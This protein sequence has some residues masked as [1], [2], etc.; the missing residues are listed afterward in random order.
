MI[1]LRSFTAAAVLTLASLTLESCKDGPIGP[2]AKGA[3]PAGAN[4]DGKVGDVGN[5]AK[6]GD[7][8]ARVLLDKA[9]NALLQV[10]T[11]TYNP[12]NNVA[13]PN[14]YFQSIQ[15]K[16]YD[17]KGKQVGVRNVKFKTDGI[18][19]YSA[20]IDLCGS[21]DLNDDDDEEAPAC[22]LRYQLSWSV[23]VQANL[24]GVGGDDKKTDVVREDGVD[25]YLPDID[26]TN[27]KLYTI[28]AGG[29]PS[30]ASAVP[31]AAPVTYTV[32]FP[33][34]K[35][36]NGVANTIGVVATCAVFVDG[37]PQVAVPNVP[38][39]GIY[40]NPYLF[41]Y[42]NGATQPIP[43]GTT[44]ACQFSLS[45][46]AGSHTIQV[47]AI[48]VLPGDYDYSNNGTSKFTVT[49]SSG[50]PDVAVY[51][52]LQK[53]VG[54][55]Y[56]P[57]GG[58]T[59]PSGATT[60][61]TTVYQQVV[62]SSLTTPSSVACTFKVDGTDLPSPSTVTPALNGVASSGYCSA[63]VTLAAGT[64]TVKVT[65]TS[66]PADG[67]P[68]NDTITTFVSVAPGPITGNLASQLFLV[69]STKTSIVPGPVSVL[70]GTTN[71]YSA[72]VSL[73]NLVNTA[74]PIPVSCTVLVDNMTM[75]AG[76][77]TLVTVGSST[78]T[79]LLTWGSGGSTLL[80]GNN[81]TG[82]CQ[83]SLT[84]TEN[85]N[86]DVV[87]SI[88]VI[89]TTNATASPTTTTT[90]G[91]VTNQVRVDLTA[92]G[93]YLVSNGALTQLVATGMGIKDTL[94]AVFHNP[95]AT[96]SV[97]F[98]CTVTLNGAAV[99]DTSYAGIK[100]SGTA[101]PGGDA[102]CRW[103]YRPL[104]LQSLPFVVTATP[105]AAAPVDPDLT[106]NAQGVTLAA[107]SNGKFTGFDPDFTY[108]QQ[109]WFNL[110]TSS[111]TGLPVENMTIQ[112]AQ[113][114]QLAL[115][116]I[117]TANGQLGQFTLKGQ[118]FSGTAAD[119]ISAPLT[120]SQAYPQGI[121][122]GSLVASTDPTAGPLCGVIAGPKAPFLS[123]PAGMPSQYNFSARICT[124]PTTFN[125]ASGFQQ[126][127]VDYSQ[128]I[129]TSEK[130]NPVVN[131]GTWAFT[132]GY[133]DVVIELD[134]SLPGAPPDMVKGTIRIPT[135]KPAT[136]QQA[137]PLYPN[138]YQWQLRGA[139]N[140]T[141]LK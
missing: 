23:S 33:N 26:L 29:V 45:L 20:Y 58:L 5:S 43:A 100:L 89:A 81:A 99:T 97:D 27:Q 32:A 28:G 15:Y 76:S 21:S 67:N 131:P 66:T 64:H 115:L 30:V 68:A 118:A 87:H 83:F 130:T 106:N 110:T 94:A 52:T 48:N 127:T 50:P 137:D 92:N 6:N 101:A 60:V 63:P 109:E 1:S 42:V 37:K 61:T 47:F 80:L 75:T 90:T 112:L 3:S 73:T 91:S 93:G 71:N 54:T 53:L 78:A 79:A 116:V 16:I 111:S 35:P 44:G 36:I 126:I 85:G 102:D 139:G 25:A 125:G 11:G 46:P 59:V 135:G 51:G 69:G 2:L 72:D 4:F 113:V 34:D 114:T 136:F 31:A 95:D 22:T 56:S 82:S 138:M 10:R 9:G 103:T 124:Q 140:A 129:E 24:K 134:F 88:K 122:S 105:T 86:K 19:L 96:H 7:I 117:P 133:V 14:G 121:A 39:F 74:G 13:V 18:N 57:L 104:Y 132:P 55:T 40:P 8:D 77:S 108:V 123:P 98:T 141:I 70:S 65:A 62:Q 41:A 38:V 128:S 12:T 17:D 84:L 119:N 49:A 107:K 120:V